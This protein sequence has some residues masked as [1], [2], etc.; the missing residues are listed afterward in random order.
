MRA[1]HP[2]VQPLFNISISYH[3]SYI[4]DLPTLDLLS[5]HLPLPHPMITAIEN[6]LK[7]LFTSTEPELGLY[8]YV[9][10]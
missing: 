4:G 6:E 1:P 3:L 7:Q 5:I 10:T 8:S 9:Y 2:C